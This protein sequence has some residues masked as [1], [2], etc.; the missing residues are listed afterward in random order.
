MNIVPSSISYCTSLRVQY[1]ILRGT[2][3]INYELWT[4]Y[5]VNM[6]YM[7]LLEYSTT[8][9]IHI[10]TSAIYILSVLFLFVHIN[11]VR[12]AFLR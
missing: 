9:N 5:E 8:S 10:W 6:L 2:I 11:T 3:L 7:D 1:D 4:F 12:I